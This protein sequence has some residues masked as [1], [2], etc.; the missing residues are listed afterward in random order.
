[1]KLRGLVFLVVVSAS[2]VLAAQPSETDVREAR[3]L[4][5][6]G[7]AA[8]QREDYPA[9]LELFLQSEALNPKPVTMFNIGMCQRAMADLPASYATLQSYLQ[10]AGE[11][12]ASRRDAA[13][14]VIEELDAVLAR[15]TVRPNEPGA[16][17]FLDGRSV[18]TVAQVEPYR[19][20]AGDHVFEARK[21]GFRSAREAVDVI[22]GES[23]EVRLT[24]Q[25][26]EGD[27]GS[28]GPGGDGAVDGGIVT[29]WWFWTILGAV[30]V[31][32]AVTAGVLLW[33]EDE[34]LPVD[35]TILGN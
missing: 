16:E 4:F 31:G 14:R 33:P 1:M 6:D 10:Q 17:V 28:R 11:D 35:W 2:G 13:Q 24:L 20:M 34:R 21:H 32:G 8:I 27:D 12:S 3:R 7:L 30:V 18:G 9:A 22:A 23:V 19:L 15:V 5:D 29:K 25:P 26:Q